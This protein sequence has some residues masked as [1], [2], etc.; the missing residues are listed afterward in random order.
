MWIELVAAVALGAAAAGVVM[1]LNRLVGGRLPR[2]ATPAATGLAMIG[3]AVQSEYA[4]Y[5]RTVAGLPE[6]VEV[7]TAVESDALWKPWTYAAPQVLRFAAV[8][9]AGARTNPAAPGMVLA[10]V[11]VFERFAPTARAPVLV[12]CAERRQADVADG[13]P[14]DAD[15]VPRPER[16]SPLPE[17]APLLAALCAGRV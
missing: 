17:G 12:D 11:Y 7:L 13:V 6:G 2:W 9:A 10:E 4:W 8:D 3:Y 16:W 5:P 14:F 1:L 15:G